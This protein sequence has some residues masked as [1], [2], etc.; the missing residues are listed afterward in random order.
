M[1]Q[2]TYRVVQWMTGDVGRVGIRHFAA[3]PVFDLVGV[4]VHSADKVGK[5][6]GEI[7]GIAPIGLTATDDMFQHADHFADSSGPARTS[8]P[9]PVSSIRHP[10]FAHPPSRSAPP[11]PTVAPRSTGAVSTPAMPATSCR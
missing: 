7:A 3:N 5:D 8:S 10:I 1:S 6:A 2:N 9:P 4:L 11:A